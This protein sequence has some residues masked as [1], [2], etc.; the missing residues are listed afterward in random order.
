MYSVRWHNR[1][2]HLWLSPELVDILKELKWDRLRIELLMYNQ[3]L[4]LR[5]CKA[6]ES[7]RTIRRANDRRH[8][9]QAKNMLTVLRSWGFSAGTWRADWMA[10]EQ[11]FVVDLAQLADQSTDTA[12]RKMSA[13]EK[14]NLLIE[15]IEMQ[16]SYL[17][18]PAVH[19]HVI[20]E[21][22]RRLLVEL[23]SVI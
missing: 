5:R 23:K 21:E 4:L 20:G 8:F 7:G 9:L 6:V 13:R 14:K 19:R 15:M 18:Q 12:P 3:Q 22:M 17:L 10:N 2:V 16:L 1:G 11:V